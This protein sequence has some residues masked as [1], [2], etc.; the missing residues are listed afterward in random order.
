MAC[1]FLKCF[2]K[3]TCSTQ[4]EFHVDFLCASTWRWLCRKAG[5][6]TAL[7]LRVYVLCVE[8]AQCW[9]RPSDL[10]YQWKEVLCDWATD[11]SG[12]QRALKRAPDHW[13]SQCLRSSWRDLAGSWNESAGALWS[14]WKFAAIVNYFTTEWFSW[15]GIVSVLATI[16]IHSLACPQRATFKLNSN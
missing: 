12:C 8:A 5:K 6:Q 4:I 2:W 11:G 1:A 7:Q 3:C 16:V 15:M 13:R 14:V 10:F 9:I